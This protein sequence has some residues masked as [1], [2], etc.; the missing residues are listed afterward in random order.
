MA[1]PGNGRDLTISSAGV[2]IAGVRT[3]G[4]SV[5][6]T[7]IDVTNEDD[8]G[9]RKLLVEAGEVTVDISMD[10]VTK[11]STLRSAALDPTNALEALT[12]TFPDASTITG[13]FFITSYEETGTYNDAIT[14]SASLQSAG[15][16][17]GAP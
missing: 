8:D 7:P 3:K 9:V 5:N 1:Y 10:G 4:I 2:T 12:I 15:A 14:F 11:N 6:R 16:L 17:V 13:S